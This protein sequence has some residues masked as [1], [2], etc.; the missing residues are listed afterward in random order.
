MTHD[1][2]FC[3][4]TLDSPAPPGRLGAWV[5][6]PAGASRLRR[7]A[8]G[9]LAAMA[10]LVA[11]LA[12]LWPV[13]SQAQSDWATCAEEG[14]VC[15]FEGE[16]LVRYGTAGQHSFRVARHRLLCDNDEFGDPA[17]GQPKRCQVSLGW[18]QDERYRHWRDAGHR[19]DGGWLLCAAEG[20]LCRLPAAATVRYG[21]GA[22]FTE[23]SASQAVV[24][25]NASFGDPA[26]GTAKQC[27]Y[28]LVPG[29]GGAGAGLAWQACADEGGACRFSG[30]ALVRYGLGRQQVYREAHNGLLC[31]NSSFQADPAPDRPKQCQVLLPLH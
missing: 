23:R 28:R 3:R 7:L 19:D 29:A 2:R 16:A 14:Q 22:Q 20:E 26:P 8:C 1:H 9:A 25:S 31:S 30:T 5:G 27:A 6:V 17:P 21:S 24:C 10:V 18:R 13:A 12:A 15:R 11:T 4:T